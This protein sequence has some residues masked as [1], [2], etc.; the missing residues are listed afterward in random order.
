MDG[1]NTVDTTR[2]PCDSAVEMAAEVSRMQWPVIPMLKSPKVVIL[3]PDSEF[4]YSYMASSLVHDPIMGTLLFNS[5]NGLND[6]TRE[7]IQRL[8]PQGT[9][10][11]PPVIIVG[12]FRPKVAKEVE[13]L[14]YDVLEIGGKNVFET[15]A[16]V[17]RFREEIPPD[18][19]DG[20]KSIFIVSAD[21][22]FEGLPAPY[23]S[24]HSGVP[25]L[26][27]TPSR[28]SPTTKKILEEMSG[29]YVYVVGSKRAVSE[30]VVREISNIVDK[31]VRRIEGKDP[32]AT[33]VE[34][35][36][37]HDS[38][39]GLGWNRNK[40]GRGDVFSFTNIERWDL[41]VAAVAFAHQGK[42][43]PLL[44]V[45][46]ESMPDSVLEYLNYL[47]PS[48]NSMHPMPPFMHGFILGTQDAIPYEI[49]AE[50]EMALKIDEQLTKGHKK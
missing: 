39:T 26:L 7:E 43:T 17:A 35:A 27:T 24:A 10:G 42:H 48:L 33:A 25:I 47:K 6:I 19:P 9:K 49:Q 37:Y 21:S 46:S 45:S 20:A 1:L 8:N 38:E 29:K 36:S 50:I 15:A 5:P 44:L 4:Y 34:F 30:K 11:V 16:N 40:K 3:V 41:A 22:P 28:L 14:G 13:N 12:P 31:P 18:S 32:Y 2:I 23:Y